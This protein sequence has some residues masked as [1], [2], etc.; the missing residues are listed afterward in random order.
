MQTE[1]D[2]FPFEPCPFRV[3]AATA[4]DIGRERKNNEDRVLVAD[5]ASGVAFSS[6][7][8]ASS[9]A[10]CGDWLAAVCDGMGGEAGG[11]I[12]SGLAVDVMLR[13]LL[14]SRASGGTSHVGDLL[15]EA[16]R[17][18][19]ERASQVV[20]AEAQR[21]PEL[22]RMG[23]TATVAILGDEE[24]VIGQVGDSRAYLLR[25][26]ALLQ[27]TRDQTL[28]ALIAERTP[29]V[30]I[31]TEI[32]GTNVILQAVGAKPR[33][34][35]AVTRVPIIAGDTLLL[36][37]DGLFGPVSDD[38]IRSTLMACATPAETCTALIHAANERGGPD[39]VSCI[40]ARFCR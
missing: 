37:S 39:N 33:V 19:V 2:P 8:E 6:D 26:G 30:P 40:V 12:A 16:L 38:I 21:V 17:G 27:L 13:S 9:Q 32:V 31:S 14:A 15:V 35:V 29:R 7:V 11:E 23:T 18:A 36:C 5:L 25:R 1:R 10:S 3:D 34:N 20:F 28:A 24:I 22:A 4:C